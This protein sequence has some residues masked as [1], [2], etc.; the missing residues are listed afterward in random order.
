[1]NLPSSHCIELVEKTASALDMRALQTLFVSTQKNK[2]E[3]CFAYAIRYI[4][5]LWSRTKLK[6]KSRD[7]MKILSARAKLFKQVFT[8]S[9]THQDLIEYVRIITDWFPF[10]VVSATKYMLQ[11]AYL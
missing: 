4:Y 9:I 8:P 2:I 7:I 6:T 10:T 11:N 3:I 5:F 1:M